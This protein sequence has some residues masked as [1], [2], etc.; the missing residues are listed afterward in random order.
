MHPFKGQSTYQHVWKETG[1]PRQAQGGHANFFAGRDGLD[2]RVTGACPPAHV[3]PTS[4]IRNWRRTETEHTLAGDR[5]YVSRRRNWREP[6]QDSKR[7][8]TA[9]TIRRGH[10]Y[11][12][13]VTLAVIRARDPQCCEAEALTQ[14]HY[15]APIDLHLIFLNC[16]Y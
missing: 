1:V 13:V 9:F 11:L 16:I 5:N 2:G 12:Q 8:W 6:A 7:W 10:P 14:C 15:A 4:R 3:W